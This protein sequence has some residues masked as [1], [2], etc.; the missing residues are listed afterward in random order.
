MQTTEFVSHRVM[1]G[2]TSCGS[3]CEEFDT[4][5]VRRDNW[6]NFYCVQLVVPCNLYNIDTFCRL[7]AASMLH[8]VVNLRWTPSCLALLLLAPIVIARVHL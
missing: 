5:Q 4:M 1:V 3:L 6:D 2:G 8:S 7:Q